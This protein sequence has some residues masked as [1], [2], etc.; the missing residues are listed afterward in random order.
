MPKTVKYHDSVNAKFG[1]N[2]KTS[3]ENELDKFWYFF[4]SASPLLNN[5]NQLAFVKGYVIDI[6]IIKN[7]LIRDPHKK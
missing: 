5:T 3:S 1:Y 6:K 7:I 4:E 2:H